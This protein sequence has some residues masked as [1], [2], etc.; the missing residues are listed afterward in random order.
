MRNLK[1]VFKKQ[2]KITLKNPETLIQFI[3]YPVLAWAILWFMTMDYEAYAGYV[4]AEAQAAID[5]MIDAINAAMPNMVT[6]QATIFAGMALIPVVAAVLAEDIEKKR[7]RFLS[8]AGVKPASYLIGISGVMLLA[9]LGTSFA[10]SWISGFRGADLWVFMGAMMGGVVVSIIIGAM[11]GMLTKNLQ[12][13]QGLAMPF[14]LV[15]GFGPFI[16]QF[17][18]RAATVLHPLF[19]QQINVVA[20]ILD[21]RNDAPLWQS[22]AII[23]A[24]AVVFGVLFAIVCKKKGIKG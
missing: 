4:T 10:F 22:F 24:N 15:L 16:S 14:G 8:M 6:M 17:N 18:D 1:A 19:T 7:L 13:A 12:S 23:G 11:I 21:G 3:I 5:N 20:D 2:L 9:S